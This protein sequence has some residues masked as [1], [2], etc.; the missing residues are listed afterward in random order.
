MKALS[1]LFL[2]LVLTVELMAANNAKPARRVP[3]D[4]A[5]RPR[6]GA[7]AGAG[8]FEQVLTDEQRKEFRE[9]MQANGAKTR[10]SQQES[11]KLRRELQEAVVNGKADGAFIKAQ[12]EAIAKL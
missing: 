4:G 10:A 3:A 12:A 11:V 1:V 5:N 2:S 9:Q 7:A 6:A 8:G